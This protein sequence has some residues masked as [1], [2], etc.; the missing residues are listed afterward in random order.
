MPSYVLKGG[1]KPPIEMVNYLQENRENYL[2]ITLE[3]EGSHDRLRRSFHA[4][5]KA[6]FD[7]GEFSANGSDIRSYEKLRNYYKLEGCENVPEFYIYKNNYYKTREDL[8]NN[9]DEDFNIKYVIVEPKSWTDMTKKEKS[10]ALD[11]LLTEIRMSS[12]SNQNVLSWVNKI[13]GDI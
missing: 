12:T 1:E 11:C 4:L 13:Q 5:V 10:K 7:S 9:I 6:W 3:V 8:K 2:R